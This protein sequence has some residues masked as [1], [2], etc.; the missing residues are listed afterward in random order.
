M[1]PWSKAVCGI[2]VSIGQGDEG[3]ACMEL[4]FIDRRATEARLNLPWYVA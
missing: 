3:I 1:L 4:A 2:V